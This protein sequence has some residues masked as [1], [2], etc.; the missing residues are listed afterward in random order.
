LANLIGLSLKSGIYF[1]IVTKE[2]IVHLQK[3]LTFL[4]KPNVSRKRDNNTV[5]YRFE[6]EF[7]PV[8]KLKLKIETNCRED[9]AVL[10][11]EKKPF[12]V[13]STWFRGEC[14]LTTYRLEELLGTKLRA[15]YQR[16]KGRD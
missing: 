14:D 9:F 12:T 3:A 8:Q 10:G 5:H 2:T 15:L 6:S 7:P 13:K 1:L 11:W 4:G 16:R